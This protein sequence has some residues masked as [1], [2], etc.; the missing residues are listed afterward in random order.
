MAKKRHIFRLFV[1]VTMAIMFFFNYSVSAKADELSQ[2][3]FEEPEHG[4]IEGVAATISYGS[5]IE[6]NMA[7][8]AVKLV[9]DAGYQFD[10]WED[11]D[12]KFTF[13]AGFGGSYII[14]AKGSGT[15]TVRALFSLI[16]APPV[17]PV[18]PAQPGASEEEIKRDREIQAFKNYCENTAIIVEQMQ[19]LKEMGIEVEPVVWDE[20]ISIPRNIMLAVKG[21]PDAVIYYE[22][23]YEGKHYSIKVT[24]SSL[25]DENV[26]WFGPDYLYEIYGGV[27]T[28]LNTVSE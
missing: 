23:D 22:Q 16:S 12:G 19:Q 24:D 28:P 27:I 4:A 6:L 14:K 9:P 8:V 18:T 21:N 15:Y 25:I 1:G 10:S 13:T 7:G 20:G 11:V 5:P 3:I 26:E 17:P 2:V